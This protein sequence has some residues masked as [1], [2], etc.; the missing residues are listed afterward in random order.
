MNGREESNF[1]KQECAEEKKIEKETQYKTQWSPWISHLILVLFCPPS[2]LYSSSNSNEERCKQQ[3]Y[4]CARKSTAVCPLQ[5]R[6]VY[7]CEGSKPQECRPSLYIIFLSFLHQ[8]H[9]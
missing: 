5:L 6:I 2:P 8:T 1:E 4:P 7:S 9:I 3:E